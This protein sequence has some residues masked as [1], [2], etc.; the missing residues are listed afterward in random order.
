MAHLLEPQ[1]TQAGSAGIKNLGIPGHLQTQQA[2]AVPFLQVEHQ[3]LPLCRPEHTW[4][5]T[6][7]ASL[8]IGN[9]KLLQ[10]S[11]QLLCSHFIH[12]IMNLLYKNHENKGKFLKNI[13]IINFDISG[14]KTP[15]LL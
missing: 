4:R 15:I 6:L 1:G 14:E 10:N 7:R 5:C 3:L 2:L 9:P 13:L 12:H 8:K 11:H